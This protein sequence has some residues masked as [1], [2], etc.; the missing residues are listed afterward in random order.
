[1]RHEQQDPASRSRLPLLSCLLA[2]ALA[3]PWALDYYER[4]QV[5]QWERLLR[6]QWQPPVEPISLPASPAEETL[7]PPLATAGDDVPEWKTLAEVA[8]P[9]PEPEP[10]RE[11]EP[12][13]VPDPPADAPPVKPAVSA[14]ARQPPVVARP[15]ARTKG[16]QLALPENPYQ[17][18]VA[19]WEEPA[20]LPDLFAPKAQ[21]ASRVQLGGRLITDDKVLEDNPEADFLDTIKGAEVNISIKTP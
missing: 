11:P 13:A 15:T 19:K 12:E 17:G 16:L 4:Q 6:Q 20:P 21:Q 10:E 9:E 5:Y 3:F 1:M 8:E 18:E 2:L 14:P 7:L